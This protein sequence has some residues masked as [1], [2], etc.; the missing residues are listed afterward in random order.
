MADAQDQEEPQP[1]WWT[2]IPARTAPQT[3]DDLEA[4]LYDDRNYMRKLY[5]FT[6]PTFLQD[7]REVRARFGHDKDRGCGGD[8]ARGDANRRFWA[9]MWLFSEE[10]NMPFGLAIREVRRAIKEDEDFCKYDVHAI[11]LARCEELGYNSL[12]DAQ[13]VF[14]NSI[15]AL[16]DKYELNRRWWKVLVWY[17]AWGDLTRVDQEIDWH[18]EEPLRKYGKVCAREILLGEHSDDFRVVELFRTHDIVWRIIVEDEVTGRPVQQYEA[19]FDDDA[20]LVGKRWRAK[21]ARGTAPKSARDRLSPTL[22]RTLWARAKQRKKKIEPD[23]ASAGWQGIA[24]EWKELTG[25]RRRP[26]TLARDVA[27]LNRLQD[28]SL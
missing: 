28:L 21:K 6:A 2:P 20:V 5:L 12:E 23:P 26:Y 27:D 4:I 17:I 11:C 19:D 8:E 3:W 14:W 13:R 15:T 18:I 22:L 16:L 24:L 1:V 7:I 9:L 25:E 10:H